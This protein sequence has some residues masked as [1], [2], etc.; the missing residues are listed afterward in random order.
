MNQ[1]AVID[2][3][4]LISQKPVL[5]QRIS[6]TILV[7]GIITLGLNS[8]AG[9][10][11]SLSFGRQLVD[12]IDQAHT[13]W[14]DSVATQYKNDICGSNYPEA[15]AESF[16]VIKKKAELL[17]G[18]HYA[19]SELPKGIGIDFSSY[20][21]ITEEVF[22]D[23]LVQS[24]LDQG[25][26]RKFAIDCLNEKKVSIELAKDFIERLNVFHIYREKYRSFLFTHKINNDFSASE[27]ELLKKYFPGQFKTLTT[28]FE[29]WD[30]ITAISLIVNHIDSGTDRAFL[31]QEAFA[32]LVGNQKAMSTLRKMSH[33]KQL[34]TIREVIKGS[35][36]KQLAALKEEQSYWIRSCRPEDQA[37]P[38]PATCFYRPTFEQKTKLL[39][40]YSLTNLF[41]QSDRTGSG[42]SLMVKNYSDVEQNFLCALN[43]RYGDGG[44]YFSAYIGRYTT[45]LSMIPPVRVLMGALAARSLSI[46]LVSTAAESRLRVGYMLD[47]LERLG[48]ISVVYTMATKLK[49]I[50]DECTG[51][52]FID[53]QSLPFSPKIDVNSLISREQLLQDCRA[54]QIQLKERKSFDTSCIKQATNWAMG[55]VLGQVHG[56]QAVEKAARIL[57]QDDSG[58]TPISKKMFEVSDAISLFLYNLSLTSSVSFPGMSELSAQSE[59]SK[60]VD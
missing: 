27:K 13:A 29:T 30:P 17:R 55:Q 50:Y 4:Y 56:F 39:I 42:A 18:R 12:K 44:T 1:T 60:I 46:A 8:F 20:Q 58:Q 26:C 2:K 57:M 40:D 28:F 3:S 14:V 25:L 53:G 24:K 21:N 59:Q 36:E 47:H 41:N 15:N 48:E 37:N 51:T 32:Y 31:F 43:V 52:K 16:N 11:S 35:I 38:S 7:A 5:F 33:E 45:A 23:S 22:F 6:V 19:L 54:C 9:D 10:D 49:S 34:S